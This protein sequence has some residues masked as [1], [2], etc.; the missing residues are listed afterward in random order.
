MGYQFP[1]GFSDLANWQNADDGTDSLANRKTLFM[2]AIARA[3][4]FGVPGAIPTEANNPGDL[5]R[6]LGYQS[7]GETLGSAGIIVFVDI[8]N[9]W[10]ALQHQID[11]II[12]GKSI[13]TMSDTFR[14]LAN[15]WT[16]TQKGEWAN[17]VAGALGL[18]PDDI[19][20]NYLS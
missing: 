13:H 10:G 17:N 5:T 6:D 18:S 8:D 9:G 19:I 20:G 2:L 7:T 1:N 11:L 14:G 15:S 16:S 4:G 3:E 12:A